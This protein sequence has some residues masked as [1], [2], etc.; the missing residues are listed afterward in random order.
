VKRPNLVAPDIF[1]TASVLS[2]LPSSMN[3]NCQDISDRGEHAAHKASRREWMSSA[4]LKNG[5][6]REIWAFALELWA[7]EYI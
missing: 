1:S 5:I 3:S 6:G 7:D 4:A 2:I